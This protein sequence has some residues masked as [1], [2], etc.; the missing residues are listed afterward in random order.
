MNLSL[1]YTP[2][3]PDK[4]LQNRPMKCYKI[5]RLF[6]CFKKMQYLLHE[7]YK[8]ETRMKEYDYE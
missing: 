1:T 7:N 4:T 8:G 3:L 6:G 5:T 2:K